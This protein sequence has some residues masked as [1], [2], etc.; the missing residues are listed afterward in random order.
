MKQAIDNLVGQGYE[1]FNQDDLAR[2]M[3]KTKTSSFRRRLDQ[4]VQS[5]YLTCWTYYTAKGGIGS[6]YALAHFEQMPL[7]EMPF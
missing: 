5:G 4:F 2:V 6:A 1:A 3:G 7:P